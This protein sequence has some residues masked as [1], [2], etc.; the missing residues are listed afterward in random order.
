[1]IG[2]WIALMLACGT[3]PE[4]PCPAVR[5]QECTRTVQSEV[6]WCSAMDNCIWN[7]RWCICGT[8]TV[9]DLDN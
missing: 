9:I 6:A 1:M 2:L 4:N 3:T 7:G 5:V 8:D